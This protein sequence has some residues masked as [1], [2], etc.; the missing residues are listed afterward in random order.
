MAFQLQFNRALPGRYFSKQSVQLIC[1]YD[2]TFPHDKQSL[3]HD[4]QKGTVHAYPDISTCHFDYRCSR[5]R[6]GRRQ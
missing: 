1:R 6:V 4:Y 5:P 3:V 2:W